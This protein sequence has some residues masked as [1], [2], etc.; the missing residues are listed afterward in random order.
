MKVLILA[1]YAGGLVLF[2]RELLE[3]LCASYEVAVCV[4]PDPETRELEALGTRVVECALLDRRGT[5]P[6]KDLRLLSFYWSLIAAER[7]DLVLTYTIKPNVWG[8]IASRSLGIPYIAN[9]TGLG[10]S[11]Q[12]GGPLARLTLALYREGLRGA[13]VVFFQNAA[14]RDL[15]LSHGVVRGRHEVLP[16]SG[17]NTSRFAS[18]EYP[19]PQEPVTFLTVGRIMRDKGTLELIEAACEVRPR[20]PEARFVLVGGFDESL[21]DLVRHADEAE[22]I[23]YAGPK[24]DVRPYYDQCSALVH[25]SWHEGMSNVCLEAAAS[26]RPVIASDV[27]GCRETFDEG[28]TGIGFEPRNPQSLA[29][30][31]ERFLATSWE[32]RRAMGLAGRAKVEREFDRQIVVDRYLVEI[33]RATNE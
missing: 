16:G 11:I 4:P 3:E 2:R 13:S 32:D 27:P 20:H 30:A 1:N 33:E 9:V 31:I 29:G 26:G 10:T 18:A 14:N 15:M 8:G 6:L 17:V 24:A 19:G 28:V 5:D 21:E 22:I 12:N 25:P 7:P 23:E